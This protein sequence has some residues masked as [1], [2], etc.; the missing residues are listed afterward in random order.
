MEAARRQRKT[1]N[2]KT[3]RHRKGDV[4]GDDANRQWLVFGSLC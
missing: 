2:I 4:D 3:E 1:E